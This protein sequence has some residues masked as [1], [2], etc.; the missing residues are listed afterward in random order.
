MGY[1]KMNY[2]ELSES[3]HYLTRLKTS[4]TQK[5]QDIDDLK[6]QKGPDIDD[7]V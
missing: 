1:L 7:P 3:N 5:G 6:A 2:S 4:M